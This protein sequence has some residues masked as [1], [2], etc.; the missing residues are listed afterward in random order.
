MSQPI[1]LSF[2]SFPLDS[3]ACIAQTFTPTTWHWAASLC[4]TPAGRGSVEMCR[5]VHPW[6]CSKAIWMW[7][8][9]FSGERSGLGGLQRF[10]PTWTSL[11]FC[12]K[13]LIAPGDR[14]KYL[15][16]QEYW[17]AWRN[18]H[19]DE[20]RKSQKHRLYFTA[21]ELIMASHIYFHVRNRK[22]LPV[23]ATGGL[24]LE[25]FK[26]LILIYNSNKISGDMQLWQ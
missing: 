26:S 14:L 22:D 23:I 6:R 8:P 19:G 17:P 15:P 25:W 16:V 24:I 10:L 21:A 7:W 4:A 11:W 18:L 13:G 3:Q 9:C 2:S 5:S 1:P 20:G 12:L